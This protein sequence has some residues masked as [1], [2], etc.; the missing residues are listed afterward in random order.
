L[1]ILL[2]GL[3]TSSCSSDD[4]DSP[5]TVEE[6]SKQLIRI[7]STEFF[8]GQVS[9]TIK[10]YFNE[11]KLVVDSTWNANGEFRSQTNYTYNSSGLL[12]N[13]R[14]EISETGLVAEWNY[15]Y[16][17][18]GR[19]S[20]YDYIENSPDYGSFETRIAY[21]YISNTL[22]QAENLDTGNVEELIFTPEGLL[23]STAKLEYTYT[24]NNNIKTISYGGFDD[25]VATVNYSE[26]D[27]L[28]GFS[29]LDQFFGGNMMNFLIDVGE[30]PYAGE[31]FF[32]A[33]QL[34][35]SRTYERDGVISRLNYQHE[36]DQDGYLIEETQ[37]SE[38]Y[39]DDYYST[40][41]YY[42]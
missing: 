34:I 36:L 7:E 35:L 1:F 4:I 28:G 38:G 21:N 33:K 20:R 27:V 23:L 2:I 13:Q 24:D 25:E 41:F 17:S 10:R 3:M 22:V 16:D 9:E 42:E 8:N 39:N 30:I 14:Y 12:Q 32:G 29:R 11:G 31:S 18:Q 26:V 15:R 19:L 6:P 37:T 40:T 5:S